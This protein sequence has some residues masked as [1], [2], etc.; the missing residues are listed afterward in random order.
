[1]IKTKETVLLYLLK[2]I[3]ESV[4]KK[5]FTV[6]LLVMKYYWVLIVINQ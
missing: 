3:K 1:M 5:I 6:V 4:S 2:L